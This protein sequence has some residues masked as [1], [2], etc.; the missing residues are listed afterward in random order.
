MPRGYSIDL[1][2]RALNPLIFRDAT[3]LELSQRE[4]IWQKSSASAFRTTRRSA[5][6][7]RTW[8]AS[9][10][11]PCRTPRSPQRKRTSRTG[12]RRCGPNGRTTSA[13]APRPNTESSSSPGSRACAR[14]TTPLAAV[15]DAGQQEVLNWFALA[16][17]MEELG[18]RLEWAEFVETHIFNSNKVFAVYSE[19]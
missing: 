11:G 6:R 16:G 18:A 17:A 15:E 5:Y 7:M 14:R 2:E 8:P 13:H 9:C 12:P 4:P 3:A 1:R 19:A 10:A